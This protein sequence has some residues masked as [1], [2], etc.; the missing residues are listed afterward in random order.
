MAEASSRFPS[1]WRAEPIPSGY[2]VRDA[3]G[4]ALTFVYSRDSDAQV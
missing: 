3:K 2:V 4:Q 1:P